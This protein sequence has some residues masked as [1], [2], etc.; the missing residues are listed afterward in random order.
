MTNQSN[1]SLAW[2]V[3]WAE[4]RLHSCVAADSIEDQKVLNRVWADVANN[5]EE[6][7]TVLDLATGNGAV[8]VALLAVRSSLNI[9]AV[10]RAEINPLDYIDDQ[11]E[12]HKVDFKSGVDINKLSLDIS[13]LDAVTSQFGLEYAGLTN[14]GEGALRLLKKDGTFT[15][16]I[17]HA[18]SELINSSALKLNEMKSLL[19]AGGLIDTLN[20]FLRGAVPFSDLEAK[21]QSFMASS[22]DK[23]NAISGQVFTGIEQIAALCI[24]EP[25]QARN[26]CAT[27]NLRLRSEHA[28]I[29]QMLAA[30][31]SAEQI[32]EFQ[33]Q[34]QNLGFTIS[35]LEPLYVDQVDQRY[36][37][38]WLV[39]GRRH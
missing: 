22:G 29:E 25:E 23:T 18:N 3:Y 19:N 32:T 35:T 10:D 17:H 7:A 11:P 15:F 34:L 4:N 28:R 37:L 38:A 21:G 16:I 27:L 5:L 24:A 31:Q 30:A 8:P 14:I 9:T 1:D 20:S 12:L 6:G 33:S 26:L 2:S 36:L 13:D 39:S